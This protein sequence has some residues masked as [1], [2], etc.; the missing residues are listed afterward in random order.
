M[1]RLGHSL[2]REKAR[3]VLQVHDE[4]LFEVGIEFVNEVSALARREM[5]GVGHLEVPLRV[6]LKSGPNWAELRAYSDIT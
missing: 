6:E 4:L 3:M 5:V 1:V 2:A